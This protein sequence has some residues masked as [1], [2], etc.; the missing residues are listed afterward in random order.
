QPLCVVMEDLHW[1]DAESQAVLDGL[2]GRL[3]DARILLL[4]NFRPEYRHGWGT[5][6]HHL[7]GRLEPL[8]DTSAT[9]LLDALLGDD[10]SL[11]PLK[12]L[13]IERTDGNP[14]FVE[15]TLRMLVETGLVAGRA[16][17]YHLAGALGSIQVPPTVRAVVAARIDRLAPEDKSLLQEASVIGTD[18]PWALLARI[19][20]LPEPTLRERIRRLIA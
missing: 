11:G 4:V 3:S 12:A 13:V 8:R 16:G 10:P 18:V 7:A 14:F 20:D 17:A 6:L 9:D 1:M 15:E 19:A 2:V 5:L